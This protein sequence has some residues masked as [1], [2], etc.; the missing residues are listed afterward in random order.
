M[1]RTE[2]DSVAGD[3][4]QFDPQ[5][6]N[7]EVT[8]GDRVQTFYDEYVYKP[9]LVA[10]DDRRT[11]I[12]SFL[13]FVYLL[14]ATVG[15][16]VY[17]VPQKNQVESGLRPMETMAAP[18]GS[19]PSGENILAQAVHATPAMLLMVLSGA[20]FATGV[21]VV[22]GTV[23]GYKGG[24][25]D[26]VLTTVQDVAAAIPG[27][28]I[29]MVIAFTFNPGSPIIIGI[30]VMINYWAGLGRS[31]RSQVLTLR[32]EPYVEASRT[33][34][35]G[36]VRIL[37][38]DIIPN[39]MPFILVNFAFAARYVVFA[40]VGLYYLGVL[41]TSTGNWGL[42]LRRAYADYSALVSG[43]YYLLITPMVFI[44]L[45]ALSLVLLA[46]GLDRLF[47]PR[48]RTRLAGESESTDVDEDD[49]FVS[50]GGM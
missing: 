40:S 39:L 22:L 37:I 47:N 6:S 27:L 35:V 25:V 26:Q 9:A 13:L 38:K 41:P 7:V 24:R 12:G 48:V 23:G 34:G 19:T 16:W 50:T 43:D 46:Q 10:W 21:A 14:I 18:L 31:L 3:G 8:F 2:S 36:S 20:V 5:S 15:V 44:M 28:P 1:K 29:V 45:L 33:M 42:M 11:R 49:D 4:F 32:E 17:P 30:I